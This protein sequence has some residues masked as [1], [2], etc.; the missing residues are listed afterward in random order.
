MHTTKARNDVKK[1]LYYSV[2]QNRVKMLLQSIANV[3]IVAFDFTRILHNKNN[4]MDTMKQ[5]SKDLV[6]TT[7]IDVPCSLPA[8]DDSCLVD[9]DARQLKEGACDGTSC[10]YKSSFMVGPSSPS[11][12]ASLGTNDGSKDGSFEFSCD[13]RRV[14]EAS[15]VGTCNAR[16]VGVLSL[17]RND[18]SEDG[19]SDCMTVSS[20]IDGVGKKSVP[21]AD[22]TDVKEGDDDGVSL[23]MED[24]TEDGSCE[25]SSEGR[26]E[27]SSEGSTDATSEREGDGVGAPFW[28][29]MQEQELPPADSSMAS[30]VA[31]HSASDHGADAFEVKESR[32][33]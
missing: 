2:D 13:G 28:S 30:R 4:D 17:G 18:G 19:S 20:T 3:T 27:N 16:A 22:V 23:G 32:A 33:S 15:L 8:L 24:G 29:S 25:N 26:M 21:D 6:E 7:I 11:F 9:D 5:R 31:S 10:P 1:V 14:V 12:C